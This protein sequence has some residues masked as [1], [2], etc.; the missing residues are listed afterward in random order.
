[1]IALDQGIL[2]IQ[3]WQWRYH[4]NVSHIVMIFWSSFSTAT[5]NMFF[6][7]KLLEDEF[8]VQI[9]FWMSLTF[10]FAFTWHQIYTDEVFTTL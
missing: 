7:V 4:N 9:S 3:I 8:K 6:L 1:M 5:L 10:A 2:F